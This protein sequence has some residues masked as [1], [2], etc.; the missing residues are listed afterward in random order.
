M[1][2]IR[3]SNLLAV[4]NLDP[5]RVHKEALLGE[6]QRLVENGLYSEEHNERGG[7]GAKGKWFGIMRKDGSVLTTNIIMSKLRVHKY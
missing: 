3:E 2:L 6:V 4:Y 5:R 1:D 7:K